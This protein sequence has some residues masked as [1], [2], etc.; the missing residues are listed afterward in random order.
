M[1]NAFVIDIS[2]QIVAKRGIGSVLHGVWDN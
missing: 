2:L 1:T